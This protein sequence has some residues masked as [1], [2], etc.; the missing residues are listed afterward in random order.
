MVSVPA[1]SQ[2]GRALEK[3]LGEI[4]KSIREQEAKLARQDKAIADQEKRLQ[5]QRGEILRQRFLIEQLNGDGTVMFGAQSSRPVNLDALRARGDG[6]QPAN[7]GPQVAQT[8]PN[9][10][11]QGAPAT[12]GQAPPE[13]ESSSGLASLPEGSGVMTPEGGLVVDPSIEFSHSSSNRLVFRGVEIVSGIQIGVIEA[14]DADRDAIVGTAAARYG[15]TNRIEVEARVP[16][17]YRQDRVM[18]LAQQNNQITRTISLDGGGIG[19]AEIG[20]RYQIN[21]GRDGWPVFIG[22]LRAKSDTGTGPF[23]VERD[24]AGV[25]TELATGSGFLGIEPNI[26]V[27]RVSDPAVLFANASYLVHLP[28]DIDKTFGN[29]TVGEVDPGDSIGVG[30]GFGFALNPE[31][32]FSLG[33]KHNYIFPTKT[34]LNGTIQSSEDLQVGAMLL[35][36]SYRVSD[37]VTISSNL[38]FGMTSDSP[39]TRFTL[40]VPYQLF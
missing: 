1:Y 30:L 27:M 21:S 35:G 6:P 18:T 4:L 13:A 26:S 15:V 25:A 34:E 10:Q 5:E 8:Q 33:Y 22:G 19:D 37:K 32:S 28:K 16:T 14:S 31:F 29:I 17:I 23:D 7:A 36:M 3:E 20:A 9:Q 40:R 24:T 2:D 12:V 38:E 11:S 39:D